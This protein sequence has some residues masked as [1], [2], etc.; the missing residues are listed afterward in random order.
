MSDFFLLPLAKVF[1]PMAS[2]RR[3]LIHQFIGHFL[4]PS[5][6]KLNVVAFLGQFACIGSTF[7]D[8]FTPV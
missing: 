6:A 5:E 7:G 2:V 4:M 1:T 8:P 3:Y